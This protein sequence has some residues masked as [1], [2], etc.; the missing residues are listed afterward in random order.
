MC[1]YVYVCMHILK[2]I[3][4]YLNFKKS[5]SYGKRRYGVLRFADPDPFYNMINKPYKS[6]QK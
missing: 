1:V 2:Y 3:Y 5:S 4:I 6:E